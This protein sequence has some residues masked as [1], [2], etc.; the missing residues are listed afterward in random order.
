MEIALGLC[1]NRS[2]L[3]NRIHFQTDTI[4]YSLSPSLWC[5]FSFRY[6][7]QQGSFDDFVIDNETGLVTIS[8][9]LDYDKR[10]M[11]RIELVASDLGKKKKK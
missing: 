6:R 3:Y 7:I 8:R 5:P 9:K 2:I 11:Y 1:P 4:T 10:D